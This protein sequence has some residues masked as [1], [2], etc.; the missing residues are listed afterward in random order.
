MFLT[1]DLISP[2]LPAYM[3]NHFPEQVAPIPPAL[4]CLLGA[5][6]KGG[7]WGEEF[8]VYF[9]IYKAQLFPGAGHGKSGR[10]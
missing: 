2:L 8:V 3:K 6:G 1:W 5:G 9:C 7:K 10:M 4:L